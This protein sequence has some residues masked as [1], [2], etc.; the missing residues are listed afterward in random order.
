MQAKNKELFRFLC[1]N[2]R[3]FIIP[4]YQRNYDW[5]HEHCQ[6]LFEDLIKIIKEKPESYFMGSIVS[7]SGIPRSELIIIDGQ[8]RITTLSHY[9]A[10][11]LSPA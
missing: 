10:C 3:R 6:Q 7:T 11:H 1:E 4:V 8:Q 2:E 5:K 9:V